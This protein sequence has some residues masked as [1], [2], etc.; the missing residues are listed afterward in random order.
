V[1]ASVGY[2]AKRA[3]QLKQVLADF[4]RT[5]R[6]DQE[7]QRFHYDLHASIRPSRYPYFAICPYLQGGRCADHQL[8]F[9]ARCGIQAL[10]LLQRPA[11]TLSYCTS[12]YWQSHSFTLELGQL[13]PPASNDLNEFSQLINQ[14]KVL[15]SGQQAKTK[16]LLATDLALFKVSHE[17]IKQSTHFKLHLAAG[18]I[19]FSAL[20]K[21]F[22]LY[23]DNKVDYRLPYQ[24]SVIVFP[25]PN[26]ALGQRAGLVCQPMSE[27]DL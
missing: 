9:L 25:N 6:L 12:H 19:N 17:I 4:Y 11:A 5:D 1:S 23:Q 14:L 18:V 3:Q 24:Q 16:N 10:V 13:K 8:A 20:A 22:L 21:N 27:H 15:I 26:V 2:E 7:C